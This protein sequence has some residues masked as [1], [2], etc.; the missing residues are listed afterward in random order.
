MPEQEHDDGWRPEST[1]S[2]RQLAI[3]RP[4]TLSG[5]RA[6]SVAVDA[7]EHFVKRNKG[8]GESASDLGVKGQYADINRKVIKLRRRLWE[9]VPVSL[10]DEPTEEVCFDLIGHLLLTV[11]M[12]RQQWLAEQER[13]LTTM[14]IR[15]DGLAP[16]A[17]G[18]H[19]PVVH[20]VV[21]R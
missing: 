14:T 9:D 5:E 13:P 11:D 15:G 19:G 18:V 7:L 6:L 4:S 12:L 3:T 16:T 10:G 2:I 21:E 17:H 1:I 8:Y 20:T